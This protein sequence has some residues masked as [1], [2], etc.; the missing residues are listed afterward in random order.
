MDNCD[1]LDKFCIIGAGAAGLAASK[2]LKTYGIPFD[3]I[4]SAQDVGG[5]WIYNQPGS[6]VYKNTH[7]I[8]PK[9]VQAFSDFPMPEHYPDYPNHKLVLEYLHSYASHFDLYKHIEFDT[10]VKKVEKSGSFWDVTL[11]KGQIRRYRGVIIASGYYKYPK[12]P[13]FPGNF[14][15]EILHSRD[16]KIPEQLSNRRVLVVGAG[17][18]AIDIATESAVVAEKTFHSTRRGFVCLPKYFLGQPSEVLLQKE[19]PILDLIPIDTVVK[20]L[21]AISSALLKLQ[22]VNYERCKI[23]E[24]DFSNGIFIPTIGQ[25]IYRYYLHGDITHKPNI[26][27][28]AGDK[29]IFDDETEEYVDT[30]IYATGYQFSFPFIEKNLLN[31]SDREPHPNLYL[32]IFHPEYENIFVV[33]MVHPLGAHWL[34]YEYQSKLVSFYIKAKQKN[35][36][37]VKYFDKIKKNYRTNT[38]SKIKIHNQSYSLVVDKLHYIRQIR[39]VLEKLVY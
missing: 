19:I 21:S 25:Q 37:Q 7:L 3:V 9:Q 32:H 38:D 34:L 27:K 20:V 28:L 8:S 12:W 18:S 24:F 23:P 33:G 31:W 16:Y 15:G 22:G 35:S 2:Y 17:Q 6:P 14:N 4:E 10:L 11:N 39:K 30:I 36:K 29:V 26:E 13:D 1:F 5:L